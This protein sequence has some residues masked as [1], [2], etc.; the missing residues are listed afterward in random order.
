MEKQ[1]KQAGS[2]VSHIFK[3][4]W[5]LF[6]TYFFCVDSGLTSIRQKMSGI[7]LVGDA[8]HFDENKNR[9]PNLVPLLESKNDKDKLEAMKTLVAVC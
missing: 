6:L 4:E 2:L 9:L 8:Y 3:E 7:S 1:K 5:S